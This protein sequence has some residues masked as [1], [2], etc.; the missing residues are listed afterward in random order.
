MN[1]VTI[2]RNKNNDDI[3]NSISL[4]DI[5]I[6]LI[7]QLKLIIL[8][9]LLIIIPTIIYLMLYAQP[10][11]EATAKITS[12]SSKNNHLSNIGGV[13]AQFGLSLGGGSSE[14]KWI[15]PEVIKSRSLARSMLKRR[16]DTEKYGPQKPLINILT[17]D[18]DIN[19][20]INDE[21]IIKAI[22]KFISMITFYENVK[23]NIY[24]LTIRSFEPK[25]VKDLTVALIEEL[26]LNQKRYI[27]EKTS[28]TRKFIDERII[29]IEQELRRKEEELKEFRTR[30]RRIDNSPMLLLEQ[31]R[32]SRE[33]SVLTGV[34]TTLRQQLETTKI[35][36]LKDSEYVLV[37]DPPEIPLN[38]SSPHKTKIVIFSVF[39][40]V[41]LGILI[42][43]VREYYIVNMNRE[44]DKIKILKNIFLSHF[45]S[46]SK[47]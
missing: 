25:L 36:E 33:V 5:F 30:N 38:R 9:P 31:Q 43:L 32:I 10:I 40:G 15:Y 3:S 37:I 6:V 23:T 16:F 44:K 19:F 45:N 47:K 34:F 14:N 24:T 35:E 17:S 21:M 42:G 28:Q 20:K 46:F 26:D 27:K 7:R 13:A 22:N 1:N 41:L 2:D 18:N 39:F 11:F 29:E 8:T 12:S 4:F